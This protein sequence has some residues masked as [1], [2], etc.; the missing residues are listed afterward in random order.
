MAD[1]DIRAFNFNTGDTAALIGPSRSRIKNILVYGTAVTALTL[2][3][4][5][6]TG[7]TLL[8]I[9]VAA[10][11]NEVFLPD[12]GILAK[13]GVFFAALTGSGSKVTL[14]LA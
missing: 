4:G 2:K 9:T 11:W 3:N 12:D 8:D 14:L 5:T 1:G 10:G 13:D 6:S 7:T